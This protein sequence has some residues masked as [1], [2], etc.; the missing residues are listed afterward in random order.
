MSDLSAEQV[1]ALDAKVADIAAGNFHP[2]QGPVVD[3]EGVEK[4][5]SGSVI[6]DAD[7]LG[8]NW[9]VEGVE[10]NLPK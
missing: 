7:L 5:A 4:I 6:S 10:T 3:Q 8:I 2:F 1:A 9:L